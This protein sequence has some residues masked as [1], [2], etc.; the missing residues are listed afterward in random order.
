[1]ELDNESLTQIQ[2][3]A[4]QSNFLT[5]IRKDIIGLL[6]EHL[7]YYHVLEKRKPQLEALK[8]GFTD[9]KLMNFINGKDYLLSGIFPKWNAICPPVQLI[10]QKIDGRDERIVNAVK[11]FVMEI[12]G[13]PALAVLDF[14]QKL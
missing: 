2:A 6:R 5:P 9:D 14:I 12:S 10:V 7:I 13:K 3:V 1:M 4:E 8:R 11:E